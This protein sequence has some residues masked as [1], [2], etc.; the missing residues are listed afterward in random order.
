MR[1]RY[2]TF[3]GWSSSAGS[4]SLV[5]V[6]RIGREHQLVKNSSGAD[7][8]PGVALALATSS[9]ISIALNE[10]ARVRAR[11]DAVKILFADAVTASF[12][13]SKFRSGCATSHQRDLI[14][15]MNSRCRS[16]IRN[17]DNRQKAPHFRAIS[18][19]ALRQA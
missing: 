7:R 5:L 12:S 9:E 13:Y 10:R 18:H 19:R 11:L 17:T 15:T 8:D 4:S 1:V 3:G 14:P 6:V 2:A 16:N